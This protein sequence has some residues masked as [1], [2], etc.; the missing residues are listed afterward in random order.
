MK[1]GKNPL[2]GLIL[3]ASKGESEARY[4]L[5]GLSNRVLAAEYRT[6]LP[7]EAVLT[8]ALEQ[9]QQALV[10][11]EL[12]RNDSEEEDNLKP[13]CECSLLSGSGHMGN[14]N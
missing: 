8:A 14:C 4:A 5:D 6:V 10:E 3:S 11:R 9:S 1:L 2:V 13:A 7:D 12:L